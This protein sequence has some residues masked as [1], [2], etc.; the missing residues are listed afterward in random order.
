ML[1]AEAPPGLLAIEDAKPDEYYQA[2]DQIR[3]ALQ[4]LPEQLQ[5]NEESQLAD[6]VHSTDEYPSNLWMDCEYA[7]KV[8]ERTGSRVHLDVRPFEFGTDHPHARGN[9]NKVVL[10]DLMPYLDDYIMSAHDPFVE[11]FIWSMDDNRHTESKSKELI[12]GDV[13]KLLLFADRD[14][15]N[16]VR[17]T[18]ASSVAEVAGRD[19]TRAPSF[20]DV[21]SSGTGRD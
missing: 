2:S 18:A 1:G 17:T 4:D 10:H 9:R 12:E 16:T 5:Q 19:P 3:E 15:I 11:G 8:C 21:K 20:A 13:P 6:W 14:V 7:K